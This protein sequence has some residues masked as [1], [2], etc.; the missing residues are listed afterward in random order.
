MVCQEAL[1]S[2][3]LERRS[4]EDIAEASTGEND[5]LA[6]AFRLEHRRIR[7]DLC[8]AHSRN[9][10]TYG[11]EKRVETGAISRLGAYM[12]DG[13]RICT[14]LE[15]KGKKGLLT[16]WIQTPATITCDALVPGAIEN[17]HAHQAQLSVLVALTDCIERRKVRLIT[18]V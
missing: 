15:W 2:R 5:L 16:I 1:H 11:G 6:R 14:G 3:I 18:S 12:K 17:G 9:K 8:R 10:R 4:L 7:V 13:I